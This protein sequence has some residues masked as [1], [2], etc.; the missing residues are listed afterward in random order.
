M[1]ILR[2]FQALWSSRDANRD[3]STE[4]FGATVLLFWYIQDQ[5]RTLLSMPQHRLFQFVVISETSFVIRDPWVNPKKK[6]QILC[7]AINFGPGVYHLKSFSENC[8]YHQKPLLVPRGSR[9]A[10]SILFKAWLNAWLFIH[11]S[12]FCNFFGRIFVVIM[13]Y[14]CACG[15]IK[16]ELEMTLL[17]ESRIMYRFNIKHIFQIHQTL[18]IFRSHHNTNKNILQI[19]N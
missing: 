14:I 17:S 16:V 15:Y 19:R 1:Q 5:N 18:Q 8:S 9:W 2:K 4:M 6:I 12:S 13:S 3:T 7:S 11:K 10:Y